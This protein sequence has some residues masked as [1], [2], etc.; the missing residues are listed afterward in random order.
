MLNVIASL[1]TCVVSSWR[2]AGSDVVIL[3]IDCALPPQP[4]FAP[5]MHSLLGSHADQRRRYASRPIT[6]QS[7]SCFKWLDPASPRFL[8]LLPIKTPILRLDASPTLFS[9]LS[10]LTLLHTC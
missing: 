3:R 1:Y 10:P 8:L 5:I 6:R 2:S 4:P 9:S 7:P